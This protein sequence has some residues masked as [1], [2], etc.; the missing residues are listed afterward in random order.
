LDA[1]VY[2]VSPETAA[3]SAI[4][5]VLTDGTQSGIELPE[6]K[7]ESFDFNDNFIVYPKDSNKTNTAVDMGP[8]IKPFPQKQN[9]LTPSREP[10]C[11]MHGKHITTDD[12]H[13]V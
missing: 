12:Y 8:N 11:F 3:V 1:D 2:L 5:G 9:C 7:P 10:W 4:T 6:I 13:A